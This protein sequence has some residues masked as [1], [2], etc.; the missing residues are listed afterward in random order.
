MK[1]TNFIYTPLIIISILFRMI[2]LSHGFKDDIMDPDTLKKFVKIF[3]TKPIKTMKIVV[4]KYNNSFSSLDTESLIGKLDRL[5][6]PV[7]IFTEYKV[8]LWFQFC[9]Q[10][11]LEEVL[12]RK[13]IKV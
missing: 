5:R 10:T 4:Y 1:L 8:P 2:S 9:V 7:K 6:D 11:S 12:T 3:R 13:G